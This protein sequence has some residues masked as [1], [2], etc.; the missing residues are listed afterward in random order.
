M[1]TLNERVSA[2]EEVIPTLVT[3]AEFNER[4]D[5]LETEVAG[6]RTE[7]A[8]LSAM[9]GVLQ[10]NVTEI[11]EILRNGDRGGTNGR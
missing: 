1:A 5:K 4:M 7:V 2:I 6:L 9:V 10:E 8:G 11:L 3:K